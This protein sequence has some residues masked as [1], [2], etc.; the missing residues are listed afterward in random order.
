MPIGLPALTS[1]DDSTNS[2]ASAGAA[3]ADNAAPK[4]SARMPLLPGFLFVGWCHVLSHSDMPRCPLTGLIA[5]LPVVQTAGSHDH[6]VKQQ[7]LRDAPLIP[8]G[9][10]APNAGRMRCAALYGSLPWPPWC[11]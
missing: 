9:A 2:A 1:V 10:A 5:R 8:D 4:M 6:M 11:R 7:L 3:M